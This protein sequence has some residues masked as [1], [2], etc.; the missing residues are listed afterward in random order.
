MKF[1]LLLLIGCLTAPEALGA[2]AAPI[3]QGK[4]VINLEFAA[5]TALL[6]NPTN[7][8]QLDLVINTFDPTPST[9]NEIYVVR[10]VI[11]QLQDGG[12]DGLVT[13]VLAEGLIW[14]ST[15]EAVPCKSYFNKII[16][17]MLLS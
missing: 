3:Q 17:N 12:N 1:A 11:G 4:D 6:P 8:N 14:P 15:V 2:P 7:P 9:T 10:D 13:E 16:Y 5:G